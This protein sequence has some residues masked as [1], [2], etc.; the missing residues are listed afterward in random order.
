MATFSEEIKKSSYERIVLAHMYPRERIV[1]DWDGTNAP[2]YSL[3]VDRYVNSVVGL[4][5]GATSTPNAGEYYF[6]ESTK[7]LYVRHSSDEDPASIYTVLEYKLF[8][9]SKPVILPQDLSNGIDVEY[10][11]RIKS[12]SRSAEKIDND[13]LS[14]IALSAT[15]N[16][17]FYNND[18]F[19][20]DIYEKLWWEQTETE[21]YLYFPNT[22]PSEAKILFRGFIQEKTYG[23]NVSFKLKN[24][25]EKLRDEVP[26]S[27]Y[28][29]SDGDISDDVLGTP[30]RRVYGRVN[31]LKLQSLDQQLDGFSLSGTYSKTATRTIT[32]TGG[33]LL[34]ELSPGDKV[35]FINDLLEEVEY[36]VETVAATTFD[37]TEDIEEIVE[38]ES[39]KVRPE[40]PSRYRNRSYL[41]AD[42][43]LRAPS[44]TVSTVTQSN[45][46]TV[47]DTTD[48]EADDIIFVNNERVQIRRIVDSEIITNTALQQALSGGETVTKAP[49]QSVFIGNKEAV[50][51]R[52]YTISNTTSP[53]KIVLE[54]DA[55]VNIARPI[56]LSGTLTFTNSS[57]TVTGTSTSF[58]TEI[59]TRDWIKLDGTAVYYEVLQVA[60]DTSLELRSAYADVTDTTTATKKRPDYITDDSVI[61]ANCLGKTED[62]TSTG[63]WIKTASQVVRDLLKEAGLESQLN[64]T[65]FDDSEIETPY[66][67]S[68][69]LPVDVG[70]SRPAVRDVVDLVNKSVFGSLYADSD[71]KITYSV[72]S[73]NKEN[74]TIILRDHDVKGRKTIR[75]S[76]KNVTRRI[77]A[78]YQHF[79]ADINTG[80][81]GSKTIEVINSEVDNI[82]DIK[83]EEVFDIYLYR[84][85]DAGIMSRRISLL[86]ES[87]NTVI[88]FPGTHELFLSSLNTPIYME[89]SD[90]PERLGG[91]DKNKIA[92]I[93]S[94]KKGDEGIDFELSDLSNIYSKG[95]V[96]AED[97]ASDY[98]AA[99]AFEK[100]K[101]GYITDANGIV[102]DSQDTYR[103][104]LI[105]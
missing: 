67:P 36:S 52:D 82:S 78:N 50:L 92:F 12:E 20:D 44:T 85:K 103:M 35:F 100:A 30:K 72:L 11:G 15:S 73:P 27:L 55:E 87:S 19:F 66:L 51:T 81:E 65:S 60:S 40:I 93:S 62:G 58:T 95:S 22:P 21:I 18:N 96:I 1:A 74:V 24:F 10:E 29:S 37:I 68:I 49:V 57:R 86:K 46:F 45:R 25:V 83:R 26:L 7:T 80:Q 53:A 5:A 75:S 14:G 48:L 23:D 4:T 43:L 56:S 99:S 102:E 39:L 54:N 90:L 61:T 33:D 89:F 3:S 71:H 101:Y 91:T 59:R 84:D 8:F 47:A 42:H 69:A 38:S 98:S 79:D 104:N 32:A 31:G 94:I 2:V 97:T 17:S 63:D 28:S 77:V 34:N 76:G 9:S 6:E 88:T 105:F 16:I 13:D 64:T 70:G 41:V